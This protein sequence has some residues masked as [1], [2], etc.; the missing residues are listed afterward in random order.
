MYCCLL[1]YCQVLLHQL[2]FIINLIITYLIIPRFHVATI[3][4]PCSRLA[5]LIPPSLL[6][7]CRRRP[8]ADRV[9]HH[10][11][12]KLPLPPLPPRRCHRHH[13]RRRCQPTTASTKLP[14]LPLST[15]QDKFDN[16][17]EFCNNAD[18]DC[19]QLSRSFQLGIKFLHGGMHPIFNALVYLSFYHNNL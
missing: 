11:T 10:V 13:H 14:L 18:I 9:C 4:L 15:L 2:C 19:V 1:F 7:C 17:K 6:L 12:I 5:T 8:N 3:V 16:E